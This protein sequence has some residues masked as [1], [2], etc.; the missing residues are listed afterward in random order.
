MHTRAR[1]HARPLHTR[2]W[3]SWNHFR[4]AINETLI[5]EVAD[6]MVS[7]G[8]AAAGCVRRE[9]GCLLSDLCLCTHACGPALPRRYTY[10]NLDDCWQS[11]RDAGGRIVPDPL[12]FPSGMRVRTSCGAL[13]HWL[14]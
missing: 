7:T 5:R 10:V 2:R 12:R 8:L 11:A 1:I 13:R 9:H 3:N 4:C 6:A 14:T